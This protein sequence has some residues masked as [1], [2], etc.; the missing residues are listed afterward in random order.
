MGLL[1]NGNLDRAA[2]LALEEGFRDGFHMPFVNT[3]K[4]ELGSGDPRSGQRVTEEEVTSPAGH[5]SSTI[6]MLFCV[7]G[8][9]RLFGPLAHSEK[10]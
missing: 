7:S 8:L 4:L 3:Q 10:R 5:L 6:W 2:A 1:L 9:K